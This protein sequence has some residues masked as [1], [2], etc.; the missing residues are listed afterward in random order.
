[1]KIL[2]VNPNTTQSMTDKIGEAARAVASP[3]TEIKA[4]SPE[5]GPVSIEGYYDEAFCIPGMLMAMRAHEK[6][7][8]D[9]FIV[10]CADDPGLDA[11]RTGLTR[12]VIGIAEAAMHMATLIGQ[13]FSMISTLP[14][15]I[16][17]MTHLTLKYGF[18]RH[19]KSVRAASFPVLALEDPSS[20]AHTKLE[21]AIAQCIEQDH[22]DSIV[23]GCAGMADLNAALTVKFGIP[24]IDGVAAATSLMES[25]LRLG[26][27]TSKTN[28][29]VPPRPKP[30]TGIFK[31]FGVG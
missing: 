10:A 9:G 4:I 16:P 7:G 23:L 8:Y 25:V 21:A 17:V 26:L 13:S 14:A 11:A 19:C 22:P 2:I 20:D 12:P 28:G 3:G 5:M 27:K 31:D 18:E 1:M 30:Y 24:I 6:E 15:S 29:Y